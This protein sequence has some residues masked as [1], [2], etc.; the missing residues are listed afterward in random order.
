MQ[1]KRDLAIDSLRTISIL[2]VV[3]IHTTTRT[4]EAS[5]YDLNSFSLTLI[6][7]QLSRFA[8]PLFFMISGLGGLAG[9][10]LLRGGWLGRGVGVD[11]V[12]GIGLVGFFVF[13]WG[14]IFVG[15]GGGWGLVGV[16]LLIIFPFYLFIESKTMYFKTWNVD[17]I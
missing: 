17:A 1:K 4:L 5:G 2:A 7:N 6:L 10:V 11:Y 15:G 9:G 13:V 8:V 16:A 3:L 14:V 12:G